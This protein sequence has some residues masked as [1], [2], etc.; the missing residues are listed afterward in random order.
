MQILE[1]SLI[2]ATKKKYQEHLIQLNQ[3]NNQIIMQIKIDKML[4][5]QNLFLVIVYHPMVLKKG[6]L[7]LKYFIFIA[8]VFQYA[9]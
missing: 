3:M 7:D 6:V 2:I 5:F 1:D 9:Y 4:K 8:N